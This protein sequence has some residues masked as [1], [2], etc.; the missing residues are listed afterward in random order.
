MKYL[1]FICTDLS[2]LYLLNCLF[3]S[4]W[5]YEYLFCTLYYNPSAIFFFGRATWLVES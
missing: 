4:T 2:F 1:K 5:T 3:V